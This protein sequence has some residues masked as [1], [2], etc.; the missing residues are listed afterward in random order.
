MNRKMHRHSSA[1]S[2][3]A[4]QSG[5]SLEIAPKDT[6]PKSTRFSAA[7]GSSVSVPEESCGEEVDNAYFGLNLMR[8]ENPGVQIPAGSLA[9]MDIRG[10]HMNRMYTQTFFWKPVSL[11]K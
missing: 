4:T 5:A 10:L 11:I 2:S 1:K 9:V 8:V 7:S 3:I 6:V